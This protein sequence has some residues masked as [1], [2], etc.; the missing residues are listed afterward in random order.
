MPEPLKD[1]H[2]DCLNRCLQLNSE[3]GEL[4]A[5]LKAAGLDVE[6]FKEQNDSQR[7]LAENL[8]RTFFPH[9]P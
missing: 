4:I 6:A 8:K 5:K 2:C 7:A 9:R 1:E 3:C